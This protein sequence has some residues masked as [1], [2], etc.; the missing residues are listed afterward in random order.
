M[1]KHEA[2]AQK[3]IYYCQPQGKNILKFQPQV[4]VRTITAR[5]PPTTTLSQKQKHAQQIRYRWFDFTVENLPVWLESKG[6]NHW[7]AE[8]SWL[9]PFDPSSM[10][11]HCTTPITRIQFY[12]TAIN[13][14]KFQ[15]NQMS[16]VHQFNRQRKESL[17]RPTFT[18]A[19]LPFPSSTERHFTT[20]I[21]IFIQFAI[22]AI[23]A[24]KF[25]EISAVHQFHH[26]R[27]ESLGRL[28]FTIASLWNFLH[29]N[30]L[31]NTNHKIYP[32]LHHSNQCG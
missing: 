23:N 15:E 32:I 19:S 12:I 30:A 16:A 9:L 13:A 6:K 14:A 28:T 17:G 3:W 22:T 11:M 26:Q 25:Q 7:A 1:I 18:I 10:E 2:H 31:Y 20:P 8:L 21:T 24:A 5:Y 4:T 29:R 27:K